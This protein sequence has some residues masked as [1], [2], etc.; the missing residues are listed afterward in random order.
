MVHNRCREKMEAPIQV[1]I[2]LNSKWVLCAV[3]CYKRRNR[4]GKSNHDAKHFSLNKKIVGY[5][6]YESWTSVPH[7]T[8]IYEADATGLLDKYYKFKTSNSDVK[9]T[10]NTLLLKICVEAIKV[11]PQVNAHIKYNPKSVTGQINVKKEI[12]ISMPWLLENGDIVA[13]NLRGF[14]SK[15]LIAM[16]EY[17]DKTAAKIKNCDIY[18]PMYQVSINKIISE[19]KKGRLL[20]GT[21]A[22]W[23]TVFGKSQTPKP[24]RKDMRAY[25]RIA[26]D[27]KILMHDL[28]PGTIAISNLGSIYKAQKGFMGILEIIPPQVFAIGIG[29]IQEKPGV[30]KNENGEQTIAIRKVIPMC[31]AFDHRALNFSDIVPFMQQLD[32]IFDH[33]ELLEDSW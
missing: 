7:V 19:L 16:Q 5:K 20:K 23:G 29:S 1:G 33:P 22:L 31:L 24:S 25:N 18:I 32:Y 11:A 15:T 12:D 17:V 3:S 21:S 2:C 28:V 4:M 13:I 14:E 6:T 27:D 10:I 26:A 30:V 8:F 9:V